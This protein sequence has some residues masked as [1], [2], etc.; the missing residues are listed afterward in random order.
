MS[1]ANNL[2]MIRTA[3]TVREGK[4]LE[5][6]S[7]RSFCSESPET[8]LPPSPPP[9]PPPHP[10][11]TLN[12]GNWIAPIFSH[13]TQFLWRS[14]SKVKLSPCH[15]GIL[16]V[17]KFKWDA[18]TDKKGQFASEYRNNLF[19]PEQTFSFRTSSYVFSKDVVGGISDVSVNRM[20]RKPWTLNTNAGLKRSCFPPL[21]NL[22]PFYFIF[23]FTLNAVRHMHTQPR[24]PST[25][26]C[27]LSQWSSH[28]NQGLDIS[29]HP[30]ERTFANA[31]RRVWL[32][33]LWTCV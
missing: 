32:L 8:S 24:I 20:T 25:V 18:D 15:F 5:S 13:H 14:E 3:M 27:V 1:A 17:Q 33:L 19:K 12:V 2:C 31:P 6:I 21:L 22:C 10:N 11:Q 28:T 7:G 30:S 9:R 29:T 23:I 4:Q 26:L 16:G